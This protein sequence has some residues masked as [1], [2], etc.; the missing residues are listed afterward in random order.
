MFATPHYGPK[1]SHYWYHNGTVN[2]KNLEVLDSS[3]VQG[4]KKIPY[5]G[6]DESVKP[7]HCETTG[8]LQT[9]GQRVI[10]ACVNL[11]ATTAETKH[12]FDQLGLTDPYITLLIISFAVYRITRLITT[13][14]ILGIKPDIVDGEY[15]AGT[16]WRKRL[17]RWAYRRDGS[18]RSKLRGFV[19]DLLTCFWC[20]SVWVAVAVCLV[21]LFG[22]G[23]VEPV[24]YV[25]GV[26]GIAGFVGSRFDA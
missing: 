4:I 25:A 13:D 23:W 17:D 20:C 5:I 1:N 2:P 14:T 19:G 9:L 7:A 22:P 18:N 26:A 6:G 12:M 11:I 24:V 10:V 15:V 16:G 3:A 21:V 8:S